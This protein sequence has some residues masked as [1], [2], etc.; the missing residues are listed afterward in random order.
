VKSIQQRDTWTWVLG[1]FIF[2]KMHTP[3]SIRLAR[4]QDIELLP[5]IELSAGTA[6]AAVKGLEWLS[7]GDPTSIEAYQVTLAAEL[8]WVACGDD[9]LPIGFLGAERFGLE[10]HIA[11]LSVQLDWQQRGIGRRLVETAVHHARLMN[12][13]AV[14]LTTFRDVPWNAPSYA[15]LGFK[16]VSAPSMSGRLH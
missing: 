5:E 1:Q 3:F 2:M 12:L 10:L 4:P 11:E 7:K 13:S 15:K 14:T 16:V 8:L 6:F 9:S